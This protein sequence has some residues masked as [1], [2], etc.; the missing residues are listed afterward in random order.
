[1]APRRR[2][3]LALFVILV[4]SVSNVTV[5][6]QFGKW[7]SSS[8]CTCH[9]SAGGNS[10][11][12]PTHNF[13]STYTP[14]QTYSLSIG[15]SGGVSGSK[16]GFNL[17]ASAGTISTTVGIMNTQVNSAGDQ[18]THSLPDYRSWGLNWQAPAAG[19]GTVTFSLAVLAANGNGANTGV[20]WGATTSQSTESSGGSNTAPVASNVTY[21]PMS[22][23][24]ATGLAVAY[25]FH[26]ADGDSEQGTQ[27]KWW[28]DGLQVATI[29]D[30]HD[31]PNSWLGRGQE[32]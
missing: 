24:K 19:T 26:D 4:F 18:A 3:A 8:G 7:D 22:P 16:G 30:M 17:E 32:W 1:M 25:D 27:I 23:T 13:P 29:N 2:I 10:P 21:V 12:T 31:V 9:G 28:R 6:K 14:G 5:A 20:G 11:P 15:M